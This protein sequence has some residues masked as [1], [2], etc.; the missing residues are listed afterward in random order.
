MLLP[1]ILKYSLINKSH[2]KLSKEQIKEMQLKKFLRLVAYVA[3]HSPYYREIIIKNNIDVKNCTPEDFPE[4]TKETVIERFDDIVTDKHITKEE[5]SAFLVR[6]KNPLELFFGK[7]YVV[8]SSGS[9]GTV[10]Y[11]I[12][13]E[14]ELARG[15]AHFSRIKKLSFLQRFAFVGATK[16]HFAGITMVSSAKKLP[17]IYSAVETYDINMPFSDIITGLQKF[18]P[19]SISGYAYAL[20]KIAEA[21]KEGKIHI[22]PEVIQSSGEAI[23]SSDQEFIESVF[24]IPLINVYAATENFIM[25]IGKKTFGGMYL[26]EDDLIFEILPTHTN[27]TNL[28]NYTLPLIR[29]KMQDKLE[30]MSDPH[31]ILPFTKVKTLVGRKENLPYF[32]NDKGEEDFLSHSYIIE[33]YVPHVDSFQMH[34]HDKNSFT[35]QVVLEKGLDT[36]TKQR[37]LHEIREKL[38]AILQEK[39]M[40]KVVFTVEVVDHLWVDPKTGKFK[41]IVTK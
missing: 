37:T 29:Y 28:F 11:F 22:N 25:G 39:Q 3:D 15:L 23:S 14:N 36:A 12:Y 21:Q 2:T 24:K 19:T 20:K 33:F 16:G 7:Y 26:M 10:G 27:V 35:F 34:L 5:I 41:L 31:P 8:H 38:Q 30:K 17:F 4:L 6:S 32:I 40:T 1:T 9:S 18:Q 13:N